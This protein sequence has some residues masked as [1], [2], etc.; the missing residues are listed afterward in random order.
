MTEPKYPAPWDIER[1]ASI[2][3]L[4]HILGYDNSG[5]RKLFGFHVVRSIEV[6]FQR[7]IMFSQF[8]QPYLSTHFDW[9]RISFIYY[10]YL[11]R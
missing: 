10:D 2:V 6:D 3:N 9:Q 4:F 5:F 11:I 8:S 7:N 1:N